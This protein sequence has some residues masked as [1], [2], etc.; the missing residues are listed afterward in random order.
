MGKFGGLGKMPTIC[1]TIIGILM[2]KIYLFF[3][4]YVLLNSAINLPNLP[5]I[6]T[7]RY[8]LLYY[9][10]SN[11]A[12]VLIQCSKIDLARS[13]RKFDIII[14]TVAIIQLQC[15]Y[16][17]TQFTCSACKHVHI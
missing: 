3:A 11:L 10:Y 7:I 17:V 6:P 15:T 1:Q 16:I 2:A 4:N 8:T 14:W 9:T 12:T 5:D 13:L